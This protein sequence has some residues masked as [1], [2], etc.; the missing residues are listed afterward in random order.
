MRQVLTIWSLAFVQLVI[1]KKKVKTTALWRRGLWPKF[2]ET[3]L[4]MPKLKCTTY[5]S[6][7]QESMSLLP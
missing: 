1:Q 4:N 3:F 5:P 7:L 6:T 2:S